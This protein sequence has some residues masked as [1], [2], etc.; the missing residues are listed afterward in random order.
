MTVVLLKTCELCAVKTDAEVVQCSV[1][2]FVVGNKVAAYKRRVLP[3]RQRHAI[4]RLKHTGLTY[5]RIQPALRFTP[6]QAVVGALGEPRYA[7]SV[8]DIGIYYANG[9]GPTLRVIVS[10]AGLGGKT[11]HTAHIPV[12]PI[13]QRFGTLY[14][15][16]YPLRRHTK[17]LSKL[18]VVH[19]QVIV[20]SVGTPFVGHRPT[21][22]HVARKVVIRMDTCL[23][24]IKAV[25]NA[26]LSRRLNGAGELF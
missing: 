26:F 20:L 2:L 17:A 3:T 22:R 23:L 19:P 8:A 13:S 6:I 16:V 18:C 25:N 1:N 15:V 12:H 4:N 5:T 9:F 7:R 10:I 14:T 11:M 21:L 24:N